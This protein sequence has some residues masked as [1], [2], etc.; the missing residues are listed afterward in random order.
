EVWSLEQDATFTSG[1]LTTAGGLAFVGDFDRWVRALD[2]RTGEVLWRTRL[3][4]TVMGFPISYEVDGV[5]YVAVSTN[6]GGGS[7]WQFP[8]AHTPELLAPAGH[9]AL[10]VFR[11]NREAN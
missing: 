3:G 2:V 9:N 1:I 11:L 5:Q 10:Y 6:Q 4:S 8:S 7:P